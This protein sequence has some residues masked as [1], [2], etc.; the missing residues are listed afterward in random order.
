MAV[1]MLR[2]DVLVSLHELVQ[3]PFGA[4]HSHDVVLTNEGSGLSSNPD[5]VRDAHP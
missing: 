5:S 3:P 2:N 4:L 1:A